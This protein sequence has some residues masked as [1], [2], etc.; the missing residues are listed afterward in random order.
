MAAVIAGL[1]GTFG[2]LGGAVAGGIA[3]VRGSRIGAETGARALRQQVQDQA[4][5]ER[6]HWLREQRR[7]AYSTYIAAAQKAGEKAYDSLGSPDDACADDV[8][9]AV[10]QL[11]SLRSSLTLIGPREIDEAAHDLLGA[12]WEVARKIRSAAIALA[13]GTPHDQLHEHALAYYSFQQFY[14]TFLQ[15][16]RNAIGAT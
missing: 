8:F 5:I 3:A 14:V 6:A 15:E 16:A 7:A 10:S 9:E 1:A 12:G 13:T 2:A 11:A 4:E